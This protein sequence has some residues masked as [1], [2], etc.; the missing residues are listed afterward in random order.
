MRLVFML[1]SA[2]GAAVALYYITVIMHLFNGMFGNNIPFR[3][4]MIP[5][6]GWKYWFRN[7]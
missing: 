4:V 1:I 5:F 6:Y 2:V 3:K 7:L